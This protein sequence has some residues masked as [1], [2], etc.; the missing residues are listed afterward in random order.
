MKR[1]LVCVAVLLCVAAG[2]ARG[3]GDPA[4]DY[5][6][7]TQVFIPFDLKLSKPQQQELISFVR[8][9][10]ASGYTIRVALIG[11]LYDM[12]AVTSLWRKPQQYAKFLAA[13]LQFVYKNRLL[14]VMP[15]GF[16]F[17]WHKHPSTK[18]YA[19]LAKI[20]IGKGAPGLLAAGKTAVQRLA[21]A[22]GVT[23][24]QTGGGGG[25]SMAR[26][27]L[28]IILGAVG[29]VAL[30]ILLRLALRKRA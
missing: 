26:D 23:I 8:D 30:A 21:A 24:K 11:S 4:S 16:G 20:P 1:L 5:L 25:R 19:V 3:D 17:N 28:V 22:S 15:N 13:E 12:G 27:R 9:A 10:N 14:V 18:E 2:T 7:G 29:V 6:L